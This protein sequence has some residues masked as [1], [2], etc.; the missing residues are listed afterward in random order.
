LDRAAGGTWWRDE[1]DPSLSNEEYVDWFME[2]LLNRICERAKCSGWNT[3]VYQRQGLQ[4]AYYLIFLTRH[5]DGMQVFG[6]SLSLAAEKWR[7]AVFDEAFASATASGQSTLMDP[8]EIFK[9]EERQ[10]AAQWEERL[11]RNIVGILQHHKSFVV[12]D[13][14]AEVFDRALGEAR[15]KHL[16]AALKR[17]HNSGVTVSDSKGDLFDKRVTRA[18]NP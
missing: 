17:L 18:M 16:R 7:R 2:Q 12:R 13:L 11:E 4:P 6:E 15:T 10:L 3:E 1:E 5:R 9:H 8:D 14:Y